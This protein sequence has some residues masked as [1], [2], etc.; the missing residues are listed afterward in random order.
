MTTS[1]EH[2]V[3]PFLIDW[4]K[5]ECICPFGRE[6]A[7]AN[8]IFWGHIPRGLDKD[9][10]KAC[11]DLPSDLLAFAQS[12]ANTMIIIL[13]DLFESH[14]HAHLSAKRVFCELC[15]ASTVLSAPDRTL[16]EVRSQWVLSLLRELGDRTVPVLTPTIAVDIN[17]LRRAFFVSMMTPLYSFDHPR[18]S[19]HSILVLTDHAAMVDV[20]R[21]AAKSTKLLRDRVQKK[22]S[23][24]IEMR[25]EAT[26]DNTFIPR[27]KKLYLENSLYIIPS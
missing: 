3:V 1:T 4:L 14:E 21:T 17:E 2:S 22:L 7:Q 12:N 20:G 24:K 25:R 19:P 9:P 5:R 10:E 16:I 8:A 26:V 11:R 23:K 27:I 6:A 18:Y 15:I 13:E